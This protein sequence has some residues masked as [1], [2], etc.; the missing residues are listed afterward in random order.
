MIEKLSR[1]CDT[2]AYLDDL[3]D[4]LNEVI[5]KLNEMNTPHIYYG[6]SNTAGCCICSGVCGHSGP[7]HYCDNHK[8]L[9]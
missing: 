7:H 9:I 3:A 2:E 4:K 8:K 1:D 5:D 6:T